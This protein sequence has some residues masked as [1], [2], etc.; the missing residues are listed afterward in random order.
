MTS[1]SPVVSNL[2]GRERE[3][4]RRERLERPAEEARRASL[5]M[6]R[7]TQ[8]E[9]R[10]ETLSRKVEERTGHRALGKSEGWRRALSEATRVAN[11][12]T[13][14]LLTGESGTGK[15]VLA[16]LIH[17]GSRR[18]NRPFVAVNC[19][20]LPEQLIESELFGHERG[21]FTGA[22]QSRIGKIEQAAAGA[23]TLPAAPDQARAKLHGVQRELIAK[24]LA[25]ANGNRSHTAR[26]LGLSR[27]EL[28]TRLRRY[29]M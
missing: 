16:R 4:T 29:S 10:V 20:A 27:G 9:A 5:A 13:T 6:E 25:D 24:A 19:A 15:E 7:A 12:E 23:T 2:E 8:L 22:L 26:L 17:R 3:R 1:K 18:A 11:T 14:V 28:Y 21:A